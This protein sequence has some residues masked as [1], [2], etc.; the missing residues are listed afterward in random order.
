MYNL[1][2]KGEIDPLNIDVVDVADRFLKEIELAE[3]LDLRIPARVLLYAAILI[4]MKSEIIASEA[5]NAD[6]DEV[7]E[8]FDEFIIH[9]DFSA[10]IET[11]S[12][13][14]A[15]IATRRTIRR[16]TTLEDLV[17]E[18]KMAEKVQKRRE[19]RR[20]VEKIRFDPF[21]VPHEED[22]E[23]IIEIVREKVFEA[24]K[25][26]D[27]VRLSEI[28]GMD[29]ISKYISVLH[30]AYRKILDIHQEKIFESEIEL[31]RVKYDKED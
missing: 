21:E 6:E 11:D 3:R 23:R 13:V 8:S 9:D 28:R 30:L 15:L 26:R 22:L 19:K 27:C 10:A 2:R 25:G 16:F 12:A 5:M 4:R 24:M 29:L 14:N 1:A 18:L 7:A 17:K 31:R 20:K